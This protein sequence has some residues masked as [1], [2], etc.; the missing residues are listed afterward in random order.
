VRDFAK[1]LAVDTA[2]GIV[3]GLVATKATDWA[4]AALFGVTP[5]KVSEE[6]ER[7]RP[8][9]P[10]EIAAK[11][12]ANRL[13]VRLDEKSRARAGNIVHYA[14]GALWG[15]F[16]GNFGATVAWALREPR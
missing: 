8:G 6:E 5:A 14:L 11:D 9:P 15:P 1:T 3:A 12:L 2:I 16:T 13:G 4:Q 7:V 10:A